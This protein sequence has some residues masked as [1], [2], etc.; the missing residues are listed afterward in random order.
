MEEHR[1]VETGPIAGDSW[2]YS[3]RPH[4]LKEYIG[5]QKVKQNLEV[6]IQAAKLRQEALDHVL[7]YGPPGLG[8][9]TLA[10]A[11]SPTSWASTCALRRGRLSSGP[12]I[13]RPC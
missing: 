10:P 6:F 12:A 11:S 1:I 8:K 5:Q 13:W 2:Q 9:T 3:L 7:L 4:Y